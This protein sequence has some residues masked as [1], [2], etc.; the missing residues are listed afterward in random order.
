LHTG[1]EKLFAVCAYLVILADNTARAS[2]VSFLPVGERWLSLALA[3]LD[4]SKA[5]TSLFGVTADEMQIMLDLRVTMAQGLNPAA[6]SKIQ[7]L[8]D[9]LF[10]EW[11]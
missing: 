4:P 10:R 3:C 7:M 1:N 9:N 8:I 2:G 5:M 6:V 11:Y